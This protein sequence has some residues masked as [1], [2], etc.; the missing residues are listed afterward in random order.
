MSP[1]RHCDD[2]PL[3][4][5]LLTAPLWNIKVQ[6]VNFYFSELLADEMFVGKEAEQNTARPFIDLT[7]RCD[8]IIYA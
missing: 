5:R 4:L 1:D 3:C 6:N 2:V 7:L 8:V